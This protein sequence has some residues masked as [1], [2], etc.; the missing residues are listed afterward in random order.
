MNIAFNPNYILKPDRGR[1]LLLPK[2]SIRTYE[3]VSNNSFDGFIHPIH[4][5]IL[6]FAKGNNKDD[7]IKG[8]AEYLQI[9]E[10]FVRNFIEPLIKNKE[11]YAVIYKN[12]VIQF[13]ANTLIETNNYSGKIYNPEDFQFEELDLK[14]KRHLTP[15]RITLMV[16]NKCITNCL[17][18][19][20]DRNNKID[21]KIPFNKMI[22]IINEAVKLNVIN[23]DVSGGEF[24]LYKHWKELLSILLKNEFTPFISTKM[25]IKENNIIFLKNINVPD[26]QISLDTLIP[27]NLIRILDVNKN[28]ITRKYASCIFLFIFIK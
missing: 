7:V 14:L 9:N 6:S 4:A 21:C 28:Y 25:P 26:L 17:Y 8:A 27:N 2:D 23:I 11:P 10:N 12:V 15:S 20:A 13:P 22:K 18:C 3:G 5:M 19:Y 24:F 1:V 16:N